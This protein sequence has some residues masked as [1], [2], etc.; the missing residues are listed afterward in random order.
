MTV[1]FLVFLLFAGLVYFSQWD[2]LDRKKVLYVPP[3]K[4]SYTRASKSLAELA[5][6]RKAID[7][8]F[9]AGAIPHAATDDADDVE[10]DRRNRRIRSM[11]R[12]L[13]RCMSKPEEVSILIAGNLLPRFLHALRRY[14][15]WVWFFSE[16]S[17][18]STRVMRFVMTFKF[19]LTSL[20]ITTVLYDINYP[21]AQ[22]CLGFNNLA[23]ACLKTPSNIL[24][25]KPICTYDYA[26]NLCTPRPP[27]DN[28]SFLI[29][30]AFLTVVV[31]I[32]FNLIFTLV[33]KLFCSKRPHAEAFGLNS[34]EWLGSADP[35]VSKQAASAAEESKRIA[36]VARSVHGAL[37]RYCERRAEGLCGP[38]EVK[39]MDHVLRK[40]GLVIS[41]ENRIEL[42]TYSRL[43]WNDAHQC[44]RYRVEASLKDAREIQQN[45]EQYS[46]ESQ[47][48]SYLVQHFLINR[49][50]FV[51]RVALYRYFAHRARGVPK[52]IHPVIWILA[53]LFIIASL[54]C[55]I[56]WILWWGTAHAHSSTISNWGINFGLINF[57]EVFIFS[58]ARIFFVNVLAVET[59][60][61]QLK[62]LYR[63]LI[64]K[65][66]E[67]NKRGPAQDLERKDD[68]KHFL[69]QYLDP[70]LWAAKLSGFHNFDC[71]SD[72]DL[73]KLPNGNSIVMDDFEDE[74]GIASV[75]RLEPG[76][77]V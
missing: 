2:A 20:F 57:Q 73:S 65:A 9:L 12:A 58:I 10:F 16:G 54:I 60:R 53:W 75:I 29:I 59:I 3:Q 61:P 43:W 37:S 18:K 1:L 6:H 28:P 38:D 68:G 26:T 21:S 31:M 63:F 35:V 13:S 67:S 49:F 8:A 36:A 69:L 52:T 47:K 55:F 30:V 39:G 72:S 76:R 7:D 46:E 56:A 22:E 44:I 71:A 62:K 19:I 27:P 70:L 40:L 32:P 42:T 15:P 51:Y 33:L 41:G 23:S 11:H 48:E 64:S 4:G 74:G 24:S 34:F 5:A 50:G 25:D 17:R 66:K 14:H 77:E 45:M